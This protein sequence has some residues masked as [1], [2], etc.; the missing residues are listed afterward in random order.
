M[1]GENDISEKDMSEINTYGVEDNW[2]CIICRVQMKRDFLGNVTKGIIYINTC[3]TCR[4]VRKHLVDK[5]YKLL[6]GLDDE[7]RKDED[8]KKLVNKHIKKGK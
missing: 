2:I 5:Y 6:D 1:S 8:F 3:P 4:V 7:K